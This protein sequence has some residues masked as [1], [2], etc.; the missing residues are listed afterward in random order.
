MKVAS[1]LLSFFKSDP[2]TSSWF[3]K[4]TSSVGGVVI[5][6]DKF[7]L[8]APYIGLG[9]VIAIVVSL[10]YAMAQKRQGERRNN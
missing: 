3:T 9:S 6:I 2:T 8:L 10:T 4:G 5:P 1:M 7:L